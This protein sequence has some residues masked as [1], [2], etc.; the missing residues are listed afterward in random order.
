M[1]L[2]EI[3]TA[4]TSYLQD[5]WTH[6]SIREVAKDQKPDLPYIESYFLPGG[7]FCLEIM[8]AAER[9]G[10]FKINVFTVLGAGT[11]QGEAYAGEIEDLFFHKNIGGVWCENGDIMPY[12]QYLGVD[13]GIQ[14]NQ[15]QVTIPFSVIYQ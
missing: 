5:N 8:G 12:T 10:I 11:T 9:V 1:K 4:I 14:A 3:N 2:H 13:S 15:H 6:T 7:S